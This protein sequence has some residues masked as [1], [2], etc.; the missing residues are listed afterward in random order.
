[1]SASIW[2]LDNPR[3]V[4]LVVEGCHTADAELH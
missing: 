1:M 2:R 4:R 3:L